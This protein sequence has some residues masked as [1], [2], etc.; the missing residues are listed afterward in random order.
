MPS[1]SCPL[2]RGEKEKIHDS[3]FL[4][5]QNNQRAISDGEWKLHIYPKVNHRL[6]FNLS[7][8]PLR[9]SIWPS[10]LSIKV[11]S[12]SSNP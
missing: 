3:I 4:P 12:K 9:W 1:A 7:K 11:K 8:D 5:Y 2:I 10:A 6:L